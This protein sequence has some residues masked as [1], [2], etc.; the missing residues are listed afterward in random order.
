M[1]RKNPEE[2]LKENCELKK[3][4]IAK[5][6][7]NSTRPSYSTFVAITTTPPSP[8]SPSPSRAS[9]SAPPTPPPLLKRASEAEANGRPSKL[10]E[11]LCLCFQ[12]P[13][14]QGFTLVQWE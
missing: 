9:D 10:R 1:K 4:E 2:F 5:C 11:I 8:P 3:V 14:Q 7:I 12:H 13:V 6:I